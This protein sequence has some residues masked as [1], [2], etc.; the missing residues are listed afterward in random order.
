MSDE[1]TAIGGGDAGQVTPGQILGS[2]EILEPI[3]R[4]G[5]GEVYRARDPELD[6]EIAIKVLP[7][8][9]ARDPERVK[10]FEREARAIAGLDH[11]N[12]VTIYSVEESRGLHFITMQLVHGKTL[13]ELIPGTG[14]PL[15]EFYDLA[16]PISD[17]ISTAHANGI[18][19][20][21][22]KPSNIMVS[23]E[24]RVEILDFGL[25]KITPEVTPDKTTEVRPESL[26]AEGQIVGTLAYMSPEQAEGRQVD[27]RTDIFSLGTILYEM[28]TG[29]RPFE[30]DTR[31]ALVSSLIKDTPITAHKRNPRVPKPVS[32]II[33]RTL[34]KSPERRFQTAD[35]L[36]N[37]I[38]T[39]RE[40]AARRRS[41][42]AVAV[43][44]A[45]VLIA[46]SFFG[47]RYLAQAERVRWATSEALP[48]ARALA[49]DGD[50][51]AAFSLAE[52]V[53]LFIPGDPMLEKLFSDIS[54]S[55]RVITVP[56]GAEVHYRDPLNPEA[57]WQSAGQTPFES[58]RFPNTRVRWRIQK[59]GF[60]TAD[61]LRGSVEGLELLP[62]GDEAE[63]MIRIPE[64][65]AAWGPLV[66][67][68]GEQRRVG[69]FLIGRHEVT[70]EQ[71]KKFVDEGGYEDPRYWTH[72]FVK[73][74]QPI[75]W[76]K[77][78][79]DFEDP[80]GFAG[81]ATWRT[82]K[83]PD[84][85]GKFPVGGVSWYEAAAY[86]EFVGADLPTVFHWTHAA[87]VGYAQFII[88]LSNLN[89]DGPE[90]AD[91]TGAISAFG[92]YDMAGNMREW[93][94]NV[95]SDDRRSILGGSWQD[96][97]YFFWL[98]HDS[99][100]PWDRSEV[101]GF[102]TAMYPSDLDEDTSRD[103]T[104]VVRD[105]TNEVPVPEDVFEAYRENFTYDTGPL[106]DIVA[107]GDGGSDNTAHQ[108]VEFDA[109]YGGDRVTADLYLPHG[110]IPP[111]QVVIYFPGT[112]ALSPTAAR[113]TWRTDFLLQ[114][115]RAVMHPS[116]RGTFDRADGENPTSAWPT[117][118]TRY[119]DDL[120]RW[121]QDLS[122]SIDYLQSRDDIDKKNIAYFG[123]SWG[124]RMGV[125]FPAVDDRI[126]VL[127]L[128]SGG[129]AS[130]YA[131]PQVDQIN[132]VT[133]VTQPTLMLNGRYDPIQAHAAAQLPMY[134]RLGTAP[135]DK[136]HRVYESGHSVP[137]DEMI[138]ETNA[139]LDKYLGPVERSRAAART[140]VQSEVPGEY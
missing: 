123:N 122:R 16:I 75:S 134:E 68:G 132:Y 136:L 129:L 138:K 60:Q 33:E 9:L 32:R 126:K 27:H 52:E 29:E 107:P 83:Y 34:E 95:V 119:R 115:G 6:R 15:K 61:S 88:P 53:E 21:D 140:E 85:Q 97:E 87:T 69:E 1:P 71:F 137:F 116:Y 10:R 70:N 118:T 130:G 112:A 92:V 131:L 42:L 76:V 94:L 74:R 28:T 24:G 36:R 37:E 20:R 117:E 135:E 63:G 65:T 80:T 25:A 78:M 124:A 4:G 73:G 13:S 125:I 22:L 59:A 18:T 102:R 79:E 104:V 106:N 26:T 96:A 55:A 111:Y 67:L 11:P 14:L 113:E 62:E 109:A 86:A 121:G 7:P 82:G 72:D 133:R 44:A 56:P 39:A 110:V 64:G 43:P 45:A 58:D 8:E 98:T 84:G 120:I 127:V 103:L 19:H 93:C 51:L 48:D 38:T 105:Y 35:V 91:R 114:S 54:R 47:Y 100:S 49:E 50:V 77:A 139:W 46:V 57:E 108:L 23:D 17:A 12:I 2:Y 81:P 66:S 30:G 90:P 101:N 3:G 31:V 40:V 41:R 5:M 99:Q 128:V 89:G